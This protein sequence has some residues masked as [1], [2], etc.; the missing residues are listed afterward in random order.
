VRHDVTLLTFLLVFGNRR[1]GKTDLSDW[2]LKSAGQRKVCL[3]TRAS[4]VEDHPMTKPH[5]LSTGPMMPLMVD[6]LEA[7]FEVHWMHK[8]ADLDALLARFGAKIEA[9]CTGAH[10]G[11]KTDAALLARLPGL[12]VIGNY[13]VGYDSIDIPEARRRGII[14]TNTPDVL[15]EEVADTTLGLLLMTVRELSK[16]EAWMRAGQW[17]A[18]GADYPFTPSLRD[19]RIGLIGYGRIGKAIG[20]RLAAFGIPY[21]Y[22]SRKRQPDVEQPY[23][24]NLVAMAGDVDTLIAILPGGPATEKL[25]SAE[26]LAALGPRG[27]FINMARGSVVDEPALIEALKNKTIYSA[28]LDVFVNEPEVPKELMEMEHIVLFPHLGSASEATRAA[29]D[30]R[31]VDNLLAWA[32]GKP[33]VT[34][35]PETPWLPKK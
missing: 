8:I 6:A 2:D 33:P 21:C 1:F 30:Q 7:A 32:A 15:T 22:H 11:V 24:D 18:T 16:A 35:V 23:Y 13:G 9:A 5:L 25:V 34:P 3:A 31:V 20:R 14:I 12:R 29:M 17:A 28:G 4:P 10:T 19:R 27:I 26:V